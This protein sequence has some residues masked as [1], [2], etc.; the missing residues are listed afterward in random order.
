[1]KLKVFLFCSSFVLAVFSIKAQTLKNDTLAGDY[2]VSYQTIDSSG[3]KE[4]SY[5]EIYKGKILTKGSFK[6]GERSGKWNF[7]SWEGPVEQEGNY[8][9]GKKEGEW[10]FY[11]P[12]GKISCLMNYK[13]GKRD[14]FFKGFYNNGNPSFETPYE[15]DSIKGVM[16]EYFENGK[17]EESATYKGDTMNGSKKTFFDTGVL[18]SETTMKGRKMEGD[19]KSYF[20]NGKLRE[21]FFYKNGRIYNVIASNN[22][23]G[24]PTNG[25][26]LKDGNGVLKIFAMDG[27]PESEETYLNSLQEGHA[28]YWKKGVVSKEGTYVNGEYDGVWISNFPTGELNAKVNYKVGKLEGEAVYYFKTGPVSQKGQ[29][30]DDEKSGIWLNFDENGDTASVLNFKN[31]RMDGEARYYKEGK[32]SKKGK[33][34]KGTKI[35]VWTEYDKR[36]KELSVQD[37]GYTFVTKDE[38]KK[39]PP[40]PPATNGH[41]TKSE[42]DVPPLNIVERMP[43]FPGGTTM[44][45]TYIQENIRYPVMEKESGIQGTLY[46]TFV[47]DQLGEVHDVRVLRGVAGG[48]GCDKEGLRVVK[49]MPRWSPGVQ[50][51][52]PVK[53]QFNLPIK[54]HLR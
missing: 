40:M 18:K 31:D 34:N 21:H 11:Y 49:S 45:M 12:D 48:P 51:G 38:L 47:I 27:N 16:Y 7:M 37:Y 5:E 20:E 22:G 2:Y 23:D 24:K 50:N 41:V 28:K 52:K 29:Y 13:S 25:S 53:V 43:S 6:N 39:E 15:L 8:V 9:D 44:M 33:Y 54:F 26:T 10:K 1:M 19:Y 17:V 32:L 42:F 3:L 35:Y 4:G 14:G 30:L 46:I 36:G